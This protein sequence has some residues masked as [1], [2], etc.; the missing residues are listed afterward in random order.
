MPPFGSVLYTVSKKPQYSTTERLMIATLTSISL[1]LFS[2]TMSHFAQST[3]WNTAA[4]K[5]E[6]AMRLGRMQPD[7]LAVLWGAEGLKSTNDENQ[8]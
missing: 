1:I 7:K 5:E 4:V 2:C 8:Y 6:A 3:M